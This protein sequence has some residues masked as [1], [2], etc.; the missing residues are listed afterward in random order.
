MLGSAWRPQEGPK[1]VSRRPQESFKK[2]P[3]R[4]QEGPKRAPRAP[5]GGGSNRFELIHLPGVLLGL[6]WGRLGGLKKAPKAPRRLQEV[7]K[8]ALR[9]LQEGPKR[10]TRAPPGGRSNRPELIHLPGVLLGPCWGR[11]GGPKKAPKAPGRPQEGFEKDPQST[12]RPTDPNTST[13]LASVS[14][15]PMLYFIC[16]AP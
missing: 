3:R 13:L 8:K 9:W 2:A 16:A 1:R 10:A 12:L 5:P 15:S 14:G 7:F 4:F 6:C 11:L